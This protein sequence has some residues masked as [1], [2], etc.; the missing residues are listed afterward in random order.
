[1]DQK[2]L[3]SE[4]EFH[5]DVF[6]GKDTSRDTA[7]KFYSVMGK[8]RAC[9]FDRVLPLSRGKRLL[10]Y[11]CGAGGHSVFFAQNSAMVTGIDISPEGI[12]RA[13][14]YARNNNVDVDYRV[15][16]AENLK[17]EDRY[18]SVIVGNS[19][20]HHLD[21]LKSLSELSRV[22]SDDG[23]AVFVEPLGH[24]FLINL[25]RKITPSMRTS[26]EHPLRM[27]DIRLAKNYFGSVDARF[28]NLFALFAIPLRKTRFFPFLVNILSEI[29]NWLFSAF[30]F[31]Q[32]YAWIVVLDLSRPLKD[33][34]ST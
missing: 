17:F 3:Q 8:P 15:M 4:K 5:D 10:E 13:T 7:R 2:R 6:G 23:H 14:E 20:L 26:D 1:M 21:I 12:R 11:G 9:Y 18:F 19:I 27:K 31:L 30:P 29:D 16:N 34:G 33:S 32:K 28:F 22:L 25:Y 24:N